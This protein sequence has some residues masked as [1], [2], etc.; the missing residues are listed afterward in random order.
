[1]T[2]YCE[3]VISYPD[4]QRNIEPCPE[5]IVRNGFKPPVALPDGSVQKGDVLVCQWFNYLLKHMYRAAS[6]ATLDT[7][8]T[9]WGKAF[10]ISADGMRFEMRNTQAVLGAAGSNEITFSK[11][12]KTPPIVVVHRASD[13]PGAE[14]FT[15][16]ANSITT[17]GFK[18][19]ARNHTTLINSGTMS[20]SYMALGDE[21]DA[22][23][24][25][26]SEIDDFAT[27]AHTFIDHQTNLTAP[28]AD[29]IAF[30][31]RPT[32]KDSGGAIVLGDTLPANVLNFL[33][34]DILKSNSIKNSSHPASATPIGS[35]RVLQVGALII[36]ASQVTVAAGGTSTEFTTKFRPGTRPFVSATATLGTL[37]LGTVKGVSLGDRTGPDHAMPTLNAWDNANASSGA[38][39]NVIA[40]GMAPAVPTYP[41]P[42]YTTILTSF[43]AQ[44]RTFDDGQTNKIGIPSAWSDVGI[45]PPQPNAVG[46]GVTAQHLNQFFFE[47]YTLTRASIYG[48]QPDSDGWNILESA[49]GFVAVKMFTGL[50][51]T[52]WINGNMTV[53]YPRKI[54]AGSKPFIFAEDS[55]NA[56]NY[57]VVCTGTAGQTD[58]QFTV[59]ASRQDTFAV[60]SPG[61]MRIMIIGEK[62]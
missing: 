34:K 27:V 55:S 53:P 62:G 14:V 5:E 10:T 2:K 19:A 33:I 3:R 61:T 41:A 30:G 6:N 59:H 38:I 35:T 4:G 23:R 57:A 48:V 44:S 36:Q 8:G 12:F 45:I 21:T 47:L 24:D 22:A 17:T 18:I 39:V 42:G 49:T 16:L 51:G 31:F 13:T 40:V 37:S 46:S 20:I 50:T 9:I 1:M 56:A 25:L 60:V 15:L 26:A 43:A 28:S 11:P 29:Q 52:N 7:A 54:K 32:Y 58:T